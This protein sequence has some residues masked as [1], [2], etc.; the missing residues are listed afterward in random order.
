MSKRNVFTT[1][2]PLPPTIHRKTVIDFFH[3]HKGMI[4]LNPLV[5]E[6]YKIKAPENASADE[7]AC[8][9]YSLTDKVHYLPGGIASGNVSYTACFNDLPTGVQTHCRA[10]AGVD[11]RSIW[12]LRGSLPGNDHN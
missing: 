1:I 12:S 2:T 4:E 8:V 3:D 5:I 11:I 10:P 7:A 6:K 9:W